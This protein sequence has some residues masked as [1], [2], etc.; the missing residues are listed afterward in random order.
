MKGKLESLLEFQNAEAEID[1]L[2]AAL[3]AF[4]ERLAAL[5][6]KLLSLQASYDSEKK[7]MTVLQKEYREMES[8]MQTNTSRIS[9]SQEKLSAVKTNKEYQA[10]LK[11]ID[12][13]NEKN[14]ALEDEMI[15]CLERM[16]STEKELEEKGEVL[17]QLLLQITAEKDTI[18]REAE[19][20]S[21]KLTMAQDLRHQLSEAVDTALMAD[22]NR[23]K[24]IVKARAVV[25]VMKAICQGCHMNIPPQMFNELQRGDQLKFCPHCGRIIFWDD[26]LES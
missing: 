5:D 26:M 22:Y 7:A 10:L 3:D 20:D 25:P 15:D 1:R 23:V 12:D 21:K 11:E 4:P 9:K 8:D 24:R 18:Q 6:A 14:S 16:E 17:K 2:T 13:M 19:V